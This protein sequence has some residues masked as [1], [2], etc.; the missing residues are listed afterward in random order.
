MFGGHLIGIKTIG[1]PLSGPPKGGRGH[2][3]AVRL[4]A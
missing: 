4:V 1:K 3:I 2:L